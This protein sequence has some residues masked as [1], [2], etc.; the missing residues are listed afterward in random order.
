[1]MHVEL[2]LDNRADVEALREPFSQFIE[3][4]DDV[5]DPEDAVCEVIDQNAKAMVV[6]FMVRAVDPKVGWAM[7][8]RLREHMLAAASKMDAAAGNEPVPAYIPREREVRMD[9]AG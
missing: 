7:H 5:I 8:C 9:E 1:M 2:E 4:D 6:R 3:N